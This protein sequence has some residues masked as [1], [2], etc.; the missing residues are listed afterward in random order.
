MLF[1]RHHWLVAVFLIATRAIVTPTLS[2]AVPLNVIGD[3]PTYAWF[4]VGAVMVAV[5]S[6]VSGPG[7]VYARTRSL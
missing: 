7:H 3:S 1:E 4:G 6:V 5:G 2:D